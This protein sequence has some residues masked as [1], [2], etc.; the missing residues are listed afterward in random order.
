MALLQRQLYLVQGVLG[1]TE[2]GIS[3][4]APARRNL[5][6]KV[7]ARTAPLPYL[8]YFRPVQLGGGGFNLE[9]TKKPQHYHGIPF[10]VLLGFIGFL[11]DIFKDQILKKV[12]KV[13]LHTVMLLQYSGF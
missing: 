4:A 12:L 13:F 7:S 3:T 2:T 8:L 6:S 1:L 9:K 11:L 10:W 5:Y